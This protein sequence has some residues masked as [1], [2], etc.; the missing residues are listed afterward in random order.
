[1]KLALV[2]YGSLDQCTGG[3]RYDHRLVRYL[4]TRG[5][6]VR[7]FSQNPGGGPR[8]YLE[9]WRWGL[10]RKLSS[11]KPDLI[12]EDELNHAS[13][14]RT[15]RRL[16]ASPGV[17]IV[18]IVHHLACS[19]K[20][21]TPAGR[22]AKILE[23]RYFSGVDGAI[24]NTSVTREVVHRVIGRDLPGI[25]ALP[26]TD[27]VMDDVEEKQ[28]RSPRRGGTFRLLTVGGLIG[29]KRLD[30]VIRAT[31]LLEDPRV[32]L[33]LAG[34]TTVEPGTARRLRAL[35]RREGV[36]PQVRFLGEVDPATLRN[37]YVESDLLVLP[38]RY[39][40]FGMVY[41]EAMAFGLPVIASAAGGA[42][43]LVRPGVN[44]FLC[45]PG[46]AVDVARIVAYL[47]ENPAVYRRVS[48]EALATARR[49]PS[50]EQ[51]FAAAERW[52]RWLAGRED[53][54]DGNRISRSKAES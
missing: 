38:S 29:R 21:G 10:A 37:L 7:V 13:L 8:R 22:I 17:P 40:G 25:V 19:E 1:M 24:F 23:R 36:A 31:A 53:K 43:E 4:Q 20:G 42:R 46:D 18:T 30:A 9:D 51:S 6:L 52:L 54:A 35:A 12:L 50:W 34:G 14:V 41:L 45:P 5:H 3:Y 27:L 47:R 15:N 2:I 39:E 32:E 48:V 11:W 49:H 28:R 44:G 26:A 16:R 33:T